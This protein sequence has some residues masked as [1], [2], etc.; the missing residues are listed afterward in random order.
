MINSI[1]LPALQDKQVF[2]RNTEMCGNFHSCSFNLTLFLL[3]SYL[4]PRTPLA[5]GDEALILANVTWEVL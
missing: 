4:P 5:Q 3:K 1:T 2:G